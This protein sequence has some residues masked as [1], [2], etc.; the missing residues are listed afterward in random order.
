MPNNLRTIQWQGQPVTWSGAMEPPPVGTKVRA[1]FNNLGE[2]TVTG[3]FVEEGYLGV[4]CEPVNPPAWW[5]KQ[6]PTWKKYMLF[7]VEIERV[8][9]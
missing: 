5:R 7:G 9:A 1:N 2:A 8:A 3:Y 6:N 4:E